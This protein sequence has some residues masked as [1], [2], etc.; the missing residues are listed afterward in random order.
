MSYTQRR[1]PS[2]NPILG[3]DQTITQHQTC[4]SNDSTID[5]QE[6]EDSIFH[7]PSFLFSS[8]VFLAALYLYLVYEDAHRFTED[9]SFRHF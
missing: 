4:I 7:M 9:G 8:S 6:P 1:C 5:S 2:G 3:H